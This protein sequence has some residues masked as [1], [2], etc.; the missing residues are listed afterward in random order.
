MTKETE[1]VSIKNHLARAAAI[2]VLGVATTAGF[3]APASAGTASVHAHAALAGARVAAKPNS[4]IVG[5]GK[6]VKYSP[7]SLKVKWSGPTQKKCTARI[8][9][10]TITNK[11]K[12]S[13]TVTFMGKAIGPAI[14]AGKVLGVCVFGKGTATAKLSLKANKKAALTLHI[15]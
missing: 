9:S 14:P 15:S 3:I 5:S 8:E 7:I 10:L 11:A 6:T 1:L 12:T 13:E 4:N 2:G